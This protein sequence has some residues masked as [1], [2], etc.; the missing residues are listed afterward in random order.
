MIQNAHEHDVALY[1][2]NWAQGAL[3]EL[4]SSSGRSLLPPPCC[5]ALKCTSRQLPPQSESSSD[6]F[7]ASAAKMDAGS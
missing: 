6:H 1:N 2:A 4:I 5:K 7:A 3:C